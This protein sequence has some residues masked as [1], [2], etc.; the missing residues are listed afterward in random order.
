MRVT[1]VGLCGSDLHWYRE[2][3]IGDAGLE[4]P[5]V[6]GHEFSGVIVD[7]PR[8]GERVVADPADPL[9][10]CASRAGRVARTCASTAG[11]PGSGRP[12]ARSD[13]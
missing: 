2:G 1:S 12:M 10:R 3:A 8:A 7:G 6:L 5:L 9:R 4:G 13:R 11:L